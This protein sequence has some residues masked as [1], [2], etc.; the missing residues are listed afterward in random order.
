MFAVAKVCIDIVPE[1]ALVL[2]ALIS[3]QYLFLRKFR[4]KGLSRN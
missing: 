1:L 3:D 2:I 4:M